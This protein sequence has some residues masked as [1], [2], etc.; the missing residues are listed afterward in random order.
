M[1]KG[2]SEIPNCVRSVCALPNRSSLPTAIA[3]C[4]RMNRS[5][6]GYLPRRPNRTR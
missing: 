2:K 3:T 6:E 1:P 4:D 5:K